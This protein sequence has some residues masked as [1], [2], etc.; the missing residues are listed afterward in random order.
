MILNF[1]AKEVL[2]GLLD[3]SKTQTIRP[4]QEPCGKCDGKGDDEV[5]NCDPYGCICDCHYEID[6]LIMEGL[7]I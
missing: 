1:T 2:P 5:V 6:E 4:V 7:I 3:G